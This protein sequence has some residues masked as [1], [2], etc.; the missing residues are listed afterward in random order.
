MFSAP[1][2]TAPAASSR[3]ISTASCAAG[4]SSRLIFDPARV[5]RPLTSNRFFTANGTPARGPT[6]LPAAIAASTSF[7][8]LIARSAVTSVKALSSGLS[9][10]MRASVS[11]T[12]ADA[13][14]RPLETAC[15][16]SAAVS[17]AAAQALKVLAGSWSSGNGNSSTSLPRR[18]E[19]SRLA[20]TDGI[21][22]GSIV[23]PSICAPAAM[24]VSRGSLSSCSHLIGPHA[25]GTCGIASSSS[26]V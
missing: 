16:I 3:S 25:A 12:T 7:A 19:T 26:R 14:R 20:R 1:T 5:G 9:L 23:S 17:V 4:A 2:R 24:A 11:A 13:R 6:G 8:R 21:H 22:A 15:A 18:K 10:A